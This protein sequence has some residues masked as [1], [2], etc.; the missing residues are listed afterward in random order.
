M[1]GGRDAVMSISRGAVEQAR[2]GPRLGSSSKVQPHVYLAGTISGVSVLLALGHTIFPAVKIDSITVAL[3]VIA[4]LPWLGSI[5][6]SIELPGG[7]KVTYP[8]LEKLRQ[9]SE[10]AGLLGLRHHGFQVRLT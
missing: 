4:I 3:L 7:L 5:F 10:K 8:E 1:A 6:G 9:E 2:T